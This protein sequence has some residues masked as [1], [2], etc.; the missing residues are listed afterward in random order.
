[1]CRGLRLHNVQLNTQAP[2]A[3]HG[4]YGEDIDDLDLDRVS[5]PAAAADAGPPI[6]LKEVRRAAVRGCTAQA[7]VETFVKVE[8]ESSRDVVVAENNLPQAD[9]LNP[10]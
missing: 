5:F 6:I 2:D 1:M 4:F 3:R 9:S 7:P 10:D 8:G